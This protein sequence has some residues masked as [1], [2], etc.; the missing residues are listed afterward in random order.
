[1]FASVMGEIPISP[2]GRV[3]DS[4]RVSG[5]RDVALSLPYQRPWRLRPAPRRCPAPFQGIARFWADVAGRTSARTAIEERSRVWFSGLLISA[6]RLAGA[7]L[8]NR[9]GPLAV[10][11]L[12]SGALTLSLNYELVSTY[13]PN[14]QRL[15]IDL[16]A[17]LAIAG[18]THGNT[19][20]L[21]RTILV[22]WLAAALYILFGI[23][24]P[25][26][27]RSL[28]GQNDNG[29]DRCPDRARELQVVGC[30]GAGC[31]V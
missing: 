14:V 31:R 17:T 4:A 28:P 2:D 30:P 25:E 23:A 8:W 27:I 13:L 6:T 24:E 21:P 18:A 11:A 22:F 20:P 1:M 29:R 10:A 26:D 15:S 5:A 12:L 19:W 16:F 7:T 3:A 9:P